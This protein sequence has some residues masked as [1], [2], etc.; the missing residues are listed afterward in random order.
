MKEW[1]LCYISYCTCKEQKLTAVFVCSDLCSIL[2]LHYEPYDEASV[3]F[4]LSLLHR[5]HACCNDVITVWLRVPQVTDWP[6]GVHACLSTGKHKVKRKVGT[7]S[8]LNWQHLRRVNGMILWFDDDGNENVKKA[9]GWG[10]SRLL[11]SWLVRGMFRPY[12]K[13][14]RVA[15]KKLFGSVWTATTQGRAVGREGLMH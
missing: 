9:N 15:T 12:R 2:L 4:H 5:F 10:R 6:R 14:F 1:T 8:I 13:S 3:S 7:G 11:G